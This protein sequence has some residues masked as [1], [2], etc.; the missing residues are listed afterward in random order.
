MKDTIISKR[1]RYPE[2]FCPRFL[3]NEKRNEQIR[4]E[5]KDINCTD[6]SR[7]RSGIFYNSRITLPDMA[8]GDFDSLS[9]G[10][11]RFPGKN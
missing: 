8:V 6:R 11:K 2:R 10:G 5:E 1:G 3:R 7:Q 9:S 4:Q